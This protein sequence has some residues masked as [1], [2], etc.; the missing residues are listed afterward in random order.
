MSNLIAL[1]ESQPLLSLFLVIGLGYAVGE[2]TLRGFSLGVGAVLFVGLLIGW[3]A[4]KAAPPPLIGS[5]GLVMFLYGTGI[6]YGRHFVRGLT[7]AEGRRWNLLAVT[8]LAA[9]T[10]MV[11]VL[12]L[13]IDLPL[14]YLVG[15]F[16]GSMTSTAALQAAIDASGSTEPAVGYS[17]AYPFGV[18]GPIICMYLAQVLFRPKLEQPLSAGLA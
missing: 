4:P 3:L 7:G 2:I 10:V 13:L 8:G 15:M 1:L 17:V 18:I 14:T 6:Q 12:A 5:L 9:G 16:S 11:L